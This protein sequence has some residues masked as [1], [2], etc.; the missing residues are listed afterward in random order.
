MVSGGASRAE[1]FTEM[2][3]ERF[4]APVEMFDPFKKRRV[5]R[6]R[7]S[8]VTR[9]RRG[10]DR[11]GRRRPRAAPGGRPMIRINLLAVERDRAKKAA[12]RSSPPRSASRS[13]RA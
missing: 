2:L 13:A 7:S 10:A 1:G 6:Q 5:R 8:S 12:R 4:E 9:R 11:G 3:T